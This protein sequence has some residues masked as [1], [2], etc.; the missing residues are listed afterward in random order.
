MASNLTSLVIDGNLKFLEM[1][2]KYFGDL[3]LYRLLELAVDFGK[4]WIVKFALEKA[5]ERGLDLHANYDS[6][7]REAVLSREI[8]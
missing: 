5:A 7:L 1:H 8:K 4:G 2:E 3:N 6:C